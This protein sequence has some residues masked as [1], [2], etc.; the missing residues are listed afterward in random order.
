MSSRTEVCRPNY[1]DTTFILS[2]ASQPSCWRP[3]PSGKVPLTTLTVTPIFVNLS[4]SGNSASSPQKTLRSSEVAPLE[5]VRGNIRHQVISWLTAPDFTELAGELRDE[6]PVSV[7]SGSL[8]F[9]DGMLT[10]CRRTRRSLSFKEAISS[11]TMR[12]HPS[13]AN[14]WNPSCVH[15]ISTSF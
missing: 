14:T 8:V 10:F 7:L 3:G 1:S 15:K 11:S 2:P 4:L 5:L 13:S 6:Y 9:G 12:T